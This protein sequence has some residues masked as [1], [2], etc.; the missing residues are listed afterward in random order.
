MTCA[1]NA[2]MTMQRKYP[3]YCPTAIFRS[4]NKLPA[5]VI[6]PLLEPRRIEQ[7]KNGENSFSF[8]SALLQPRPLAQQLL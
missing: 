8:I 2:M 7:A 3:N 5:A 4:I 6:Y 1:S